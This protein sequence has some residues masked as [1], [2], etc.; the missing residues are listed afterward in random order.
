MLETSDLFAFIIA[1][2][3]RKI[4]EKSKNGIVF[5]CLQAYSSMTAEIPPLECLIFR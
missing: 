2:F 4:Y 3:H 1:Q 5:S